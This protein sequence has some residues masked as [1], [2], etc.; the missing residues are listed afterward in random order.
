[1]KNREFIAIALLIVL[2]TAGL[3]LTYYV[4]AITKGTYV[5][6]K[7]DGWVETKMGQTRFCWTRLDLDADDNLTVLPV[8]CSEWK[9]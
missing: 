2:A 5:V 6:N 3:S 1:M 8:L 7:K 4:R 9:E